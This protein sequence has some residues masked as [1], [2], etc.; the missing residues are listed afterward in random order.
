VLGQQH[1]GLQLEAPVLRQ[2]RDSVARAFAVAPY[3][4][5]LPLWTS[6]TIIDKLPLTVTLPAND[7]LYKVKR[8]ILQVGECA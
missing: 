1:G 4:I 5:V 2:L 7:P 3:L 8:G 6:P